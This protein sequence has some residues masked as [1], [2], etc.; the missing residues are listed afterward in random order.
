MNLG[1][2][3]PHPT[4]HSLHSLISLL[5]FCSSCS[6]TWLHRVVLGRGSQWLLRV[7]RKSCLPDGCFPSCYWMCLCHRGCCHSSGCLHFSVYLQLESVHLEGPS[8]IAPERMQVWLYPDLQ[9]QASF[10]S[11]TCFI[12]F[13]CGSGTH[14]LT[15]ESA[16]VLHLC[17]SSLYW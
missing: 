16:F 13:F 1:R 3:L 8:L 9:T 6:W 2:S 10:N 11:E 7:V 4:P 5:R 14:L 12:E 17:L 15:V